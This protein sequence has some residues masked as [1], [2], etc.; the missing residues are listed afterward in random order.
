M[1][2]IRVCPKCKKVAAVYTSNSHGVLAFTKC[3]YCGYNAEQYVKDLT[4]ES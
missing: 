1:I 3:N 2:A 4:E